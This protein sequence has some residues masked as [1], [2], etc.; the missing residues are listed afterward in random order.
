MDEMKIKLS[1]KFMR[2]IVAKLIAKFIEMKTGYK[3]DIQL[4]DLN[5]SFIDGDTKV[6]TNVEVTMDSKEFG[7][8]IKTLGLD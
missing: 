5:V 1:T 6:S 2:N 3:V 4:N 7:K 8:V